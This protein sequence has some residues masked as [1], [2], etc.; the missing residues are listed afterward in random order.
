MTRIFRLLL[1]PFQ[2]SIRNKLIVTMIGL[3][4]VPLIFISLLAAENTRR[5]VEAEVIESNSSKIKWTAGYL[6]ERFEQM[7]NIIYTLLINESYNEY[8]AKMGDANPST[9]FNAQKDFVNAVTSIFYSNVNYLS[10]IHIYL[11]DSNKQFLVNGS[12]MEVFTPPRIPDPFRNFLKNQGNFIIENKDNTGSFYLMRTINRFEDRKRLGGIALE[13]NWSNLDNTLNLLTPGSEQTV[14]ISNQQGE[15][16]YSLE[17]QPVSSDQLINLQNQMN[18]ESGYFRTKEDYVFYGTI[19]LWNLNV[20]KVIPSSFI[21]NSARRTWQYAVI[22]GAIS[23]LLSVLVAIMIAWKTSKPI[24]KLARSMQGIVP[25]KEDETPP[26]TRKDEIGLL[27]MRYYNMSKRLKEYIKA[28]YSINL[29]KRTAQ[30]K[31]LQA[32]VNPHFLQ[33][34]LQLIGSMAFSKKPDELYDV[35]RSLSDMFRY[36]IRD[37]EE[38]TTLKQELDHVQNYLYIQKQRFT[39]RIT[40]HM[41]LEP[42][43]E[44]SAIPKLTLQPIVENAFIHG[45]EKKTGV[46]EIH[47]TVKHT[48]QG[49]FI[50]IEDN[51]L[52]IPAEHLSQLQY[53]LEAQ[54]EPFWSG[55][56]RIGLSN[57]AARIRMHF[58][59]P[60][61]LSIDSQLG[62]GTAIR[63]LLPR[64]RSVTND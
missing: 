39:S 30:L 22:I 40:T 45:L 61:G 5:S 11:S 16:L 59:S 26:V 50:L 17:G 31:A 10:G 44:S 62:K 1:D 21:D 55:S 20:I 37:P 28:E 58:G 24:V 6:G 63:L 53:R 51:G 49:I 54:T 56:E 25:L 15:M 2:R 46:W 12:N 47:I 33:N 4:C 13:I 8:I 27:E 42:G 57:V 19:P 48:V 43:V 35:I 18:A 14:F 38:L 41:F 64:E 3:S 7:N 52:G 9:A 34:T 29:E 60:Y 32:Q 36:I 23:T